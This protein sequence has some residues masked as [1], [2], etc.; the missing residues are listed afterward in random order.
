M[1]L[2]CIKFLLL[3]KK[4]TIDSL[5]DLLCI[6]FEFLINF[7]IMSASIFHIPNPRDKSTSGFFYQNVNLNFLLPYCFSSIAEVTNARVM[8]EGKVHI[9]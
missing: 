6:S 9:L 7:I 5:T 1:I 3:K 2:K 8:L 4:E